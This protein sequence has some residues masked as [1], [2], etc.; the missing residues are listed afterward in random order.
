M[1][2][3]AAVVLGGAL[4]GSEAKG[5]RRDLYGDPLPPG[6][7]ARLGTLR[8]RG[9]RGAMSFTPDGKLLAAA[10]GP[11][12]AHI[13]FWDPATGRSVRHINAG[14]TLARFAFTPDG[15]RVACFTNSSR[16]PMLDVA[17]GTELFTVDSSHG[18]LS[19]DGTILVTADTFGDAPQVHVWDAAT[20]RQVRRWPVGKGVDALALASDD[21]T[22]A[23]L[24][25]AEPG[26][27]RVC[28][29]NT[30]MKSLSIR[31]EPG[32]CWLT[33]SPDGKSLATALHDR[34]SL[35]DAA[36]GTLLR[37]WTRPIGCCPVFSGDGR[38]LAWTGRDERR[39][40]IAL[41]VVGRDE[42]EPGMVAL[43]RPVGRPANYRTES[44]CFTPDGT[45]LA[46]V[47]EAG[48]LEIRALSDGKE[49][50]PLAAHA[51]GVFDLA[52]TRDGNH[53][54]SRDG[55]ELLTWD[56]AT[57]RLRRRSPAQLSEHELLTA[58]L[59]DGRLLTEDRTANP[60]HGL[61][62]LRDPLTGQEVL[63]FEGRPDVGPP[64]A[65]VAP[66]GRYAAVRGRAGEMCV[67]DLRTE[68]CTY[69]HEAGF[70]A[71]LSHDGDVLAWYTKPGGG[72][73]LLHRQSTGALIK[74]NLPEDSQV[75][76]WLGD[77]NGVSPD[78]RW[79]V[80]PA[81]DGRLRRWDLG[82]G[83]EQAALPEAQRAVWSLLWS[84]DSRL[85]AAF[86]SARLPWVIDRAARQH[87]L[88]WD[89]TT[90]KRIPHLEL[91]DDESWR[92][93]SP[94]GRT[95]FTVGPR[96]VALWEVATGQERL[97]LPEASAVNALALRTDGRVLATG[98]ADTQVFLW[99]LPGRA[100]RPSGAPIL[101]VHQ[102]WDLLGQDN[103]QAA[104]SALW[105]LVSEP[106][107]AVTLLEEKLRPV[108]T[109]PDPEH[110]KQLVKRLASEDFR[111]RQQAT[112]ELER[113]EEL[114]LPALR[115]ARQGPLSLE[116]QRRVDVLLDKL[117]PQR[118]TGPTLQM[119]RGIE[120][121]ETMGTP[122]ARRLLEALAR[123]TAEARLTRAAQ[124][125][126]NRLGQQRPVLSP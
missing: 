17:S 20:G 15:R 54:V 92:L 104:Y 32:F 112:K 59:P 57:A 2:S 97:R 80:A 35:W 44:P 76:R 125:A 4:L 126:I 67:I 12:G 49:L 46:V 73:M 21:R 50:V 87:T 70:G 1:L 107:R 26:I 65:T 29:V 7:L 82:A 41:W 68:R 45:A 40:H 55:H 11:A 119:Q 123:G 37:T 83:K 22:L 33:F 60:L 110:L 95:L 72:E 63:R 120:V 122:E 90:G 18:L 42:A 100:A 23:L 81:D 114:A 124:A 85:V 75:S 3:L 14:A 93:F 51:S 64:C 86:G 62:R 24:D 69:R 47:T 78:G 36:T 19:A 96:G 58:L 34:L 79:L 106:A 102:A 13:T 105:D 66:G 31:I 111:E 89:V 115:Q 88:A 113:Y 6:A 61:F 77:H 116:A 98:S 74:T 91:P 43:S 53:V 10:T 52:F 16:S 5:Q 28:D 30:G 94:D 101:S 121:L 56:A 117:D 48:A 103:A 38:H 9:V 108:T 8:F 109:R 118:L 71:S 27:V 25:Q 84:P 39:G 99:D